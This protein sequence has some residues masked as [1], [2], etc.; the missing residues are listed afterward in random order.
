MIVAPVLLGWDLVTRVGSI[1]TAGRIVEV[2]AYLGPDDPASH[3]FRGPTSRTEPMFRA[4]GCVYAY[5]SYGLHTCLNIVTGRAGEGQAVLIRALEPT[6]G[7]AE[8]IRRRKL[9]NPRLLAA[10]PGRLTQALG[11]RLS[12]TGT[13]LGG[14]ITLRAPEIPTDPRLI[15]AGPRIGISKAKDMPWR[16]YLDQNPFVSRR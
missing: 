13:V 6:A 9:T 7:L 1:E 15:I 5:R 11:I 12:D 8:M 14:T 10:G 16:F 4:G 2:E 3:A